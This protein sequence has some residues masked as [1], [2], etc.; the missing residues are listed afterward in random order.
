MLSFCLATIS[1]KMCYH[2]RRRGR[3]GNMQTHHYHIH[4]SV[5]SRPSSLTW[6]PCAM[7]ER[8]QPLVSR[9]WLAQ[10]PVGTRMEFLANRGGGRWGQISDNIFLLN[11]RINVLIGM[12]R[13]FEYYW[14]YVRRKR[15]KLSWYIM[16]DWIIMFIWLFR[17]NLFMEWNLTTIERTLTFGVKTRQRKHCCCTNKA[18]KFV[19]SVVRR[20]WLRKTNVFIFH[21]HSLS[22]A[23]LSWDNL[24]CERWKRF[25][26]YVKALC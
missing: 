8:A 2:V 24:V 20:R 9:S 12:M 1:F 16:I 14:R 4:P 26:R 11:T 25:R 15:G 22:G 13:C 6:C 5:T 19:H 7:Q 10:C 23:R 18:A 21:A 3:K 17:K